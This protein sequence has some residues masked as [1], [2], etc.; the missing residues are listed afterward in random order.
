MKYS[1]NLFS[2]LKKIAPL[3]LCFSFRL[4]VWV[5]IM[6]GFLLSEANP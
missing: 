1:E 2:I 6:Y 5:F 4:Q 3:P